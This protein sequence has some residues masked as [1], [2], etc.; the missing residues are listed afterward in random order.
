MSSKTSKVSNIHS[1]RGTLK[2]LPY[3]IP[4]LFIFLAESMFFFGNLM[5]TIAFHALNL[6]ICS[7]LPLSSFLKSRLFKACSLVSTLRILNITMPVFV[8]Y[9]IYWLPLIYG[10]ILLGAYFALKKEASTNGETS[11][12]IHWQELGL[13]FKSYYIP[14]AALLGFLIANVEYEFLRPEALIPTLTPI[15]LLILAVIMIFFVGF[16]EEI[17]FRSLLQTRLQERLGNWQGLLFASIVFASMHSG[18]SSLPYLGFVFS[19][20]LLLA[21]LFQR[22]QSLALVAVTHGSINFFLFSFLPH[23]LLLFL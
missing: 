21:Y 14:G 7:L 17:V 1:L 15:N 2:K 4:F 3:G 16:V 5:P 8:P 9:T 22:T 20:G 13:S 6:L 12:S 11:P 18:Y 19:V 23:H 10:P